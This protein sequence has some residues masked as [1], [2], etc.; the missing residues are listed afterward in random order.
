MKIILETTLFCAELTKFKLD[1]KY[2]TVLTVTIII[3]Q[4]LEDN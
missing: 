1:T 4:W 3:Y 2:N